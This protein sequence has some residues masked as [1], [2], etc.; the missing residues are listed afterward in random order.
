MGAGPGKGCLHVA[1]PWGNPEGRGGKGTLGIPGDTGHPSGAGSPLGPGLHGGGQAW[2]RASFG[3]VQ[4]QGW[5]GSRFVC[6]FS[7]DPLVQGFC[8]AGM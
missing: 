4:S 8:A 5:R 6:A 7:K 2:V 1:R 3:E